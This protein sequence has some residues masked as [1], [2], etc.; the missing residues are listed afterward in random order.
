M[1]Q[2]SKKEEQPVTE[3]KD[4]EAQIY[5]EELQGMKSI[6]I[7]AKAPTAQFMDLLKPETD[8][9]ASSAQKNLE[10]LFTQGDFVKTNRPFQ[11][12]IKIKLDQPL[13]DEPT[14]KVNAPKPEPKGKAQSHEDYERALDGLCALDKQYRDKNFGF[15]GKYF[16]S[17][18]GNALNL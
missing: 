16:R 3:E 4:E 13:E 1:F 7:F 17:T 5:Q 8:E 2:V 10:E 18:H 15:Y 6:D 14:V 11:N 12:K 9:Q